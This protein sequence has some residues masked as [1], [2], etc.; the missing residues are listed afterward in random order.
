MTKIL[1][2]WAWRAEWH[3]KWMFVSATL[4]EGWRN[5]MKVRCWP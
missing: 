2:P 5:W 4:T 3:G 1:P